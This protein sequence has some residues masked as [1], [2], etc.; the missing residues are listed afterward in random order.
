MSSR[1]LRLAALAVTLLNPSSLA[2]HPPD[3]GTVETVALFNALALETPESI[4]ED[5]D[6]SFFISMALTGEIRRIAPDGTQSTHALLP[7]GPPLTPCHGL[8]GIM[9][10]LTLDRHGNLFVSVAACDPADRGVWKVAPDGTIELVANLPTTALPNGIALR[11]GQLY[12][13][14]SV[15]L[16]WTVPAAGGT[17]E[18]WSADPQLAPAPGAPFPGANGLQIFRGELYVSNSD[19]GTIL[20]FPFRPDGS[21]AAPRVHAALPDDLGCDDFDF[22]VLG[23]LYCTTDPFNVLL[24]IRPNGSFETL[25]TAADG[26]DGPTAALFGRRGRDRFNLYLTNAAF[27]FFT[28]TFR[29]SLMRLHLALPGA[30]ER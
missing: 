1:S 14:D 13:A 25:L 16:I 18:V 12:V 5:R 22:D 23:N 3:A 17:A 20:A 15:G 19:Q 8:F 21:A 30:P 26:L 28:T 24:R 27:P 4:A 29:P 11:R 10:A 2:A 9:G 7:I 6:G